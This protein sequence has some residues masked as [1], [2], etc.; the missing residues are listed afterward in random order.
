MP[1]VRDKQE[2]PKAVS[3]LYRHFCEFVT[4]LAMKEHGMVKGSGFRVRTLLGGGRSGFRVEPR[5][6]GQMQKR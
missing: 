2:S 1:D 4:F 6:K 3:L 5:S